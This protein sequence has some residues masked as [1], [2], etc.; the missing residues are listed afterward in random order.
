MSRIV[1]EHA[2]LRYMERIEGMTPEQARSVVGEYR[3]I[4]EA[5]LLTPLVRDVLTL[6]RSTRSEARVKLPTCT[7]VCNSGFVVTILW[8]GFSHFSM[9]AASG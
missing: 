1:T 2:V 7:V 3:P 6:T 4:V 8:A 5:I 9:E